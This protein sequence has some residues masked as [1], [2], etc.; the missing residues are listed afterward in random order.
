MQVADPGRLNKNDLVTRELEL[1]R[2]DHGGILR[3]E[4]VVEAAVPEDHPLHRY[5]QWD[6]SEAAKRYRVW[7]ARQ[8]IAIAIIYPDMAPVRTYIHVRSDRAT[9][10]GYRPVVAVLSDAELRQQALADAYRDFQVFE[11]KYRRLVELSP[12]INVFHEIFRKL[13]LSRP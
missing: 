11:A 5:F 2:Q 1:I 9:G 4:D 10:G 3:P 13:G 7:Q 12:G 8:L 6:D